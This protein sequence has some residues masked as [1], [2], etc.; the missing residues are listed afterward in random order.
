MK[1]LLYVP[2]HL[3][4]VPIQYVDHETYVCL[5]L[6]KFPRKSIL[7]GNVIIS[8]KSEQVLCTKF[9]GTVKV[10]AAHSTTIRKGYQPVLHA[11]SIRQTVKI[12][13]I[14]DKT[15]ARDSRELC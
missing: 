15:N 4:R 1:Q 8:P 6:K 9:T 3:K 12:V 13:N 10:L 11:L 2:I 7:R 5:G 14:E